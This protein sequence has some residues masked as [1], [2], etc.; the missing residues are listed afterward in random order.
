MTE[1]SPEEFE[2][3][4]ARVAVLERMYADLKREHEKVAIFSKNIAITGPGPL[5]PGIGERFSGGGLK[6]GFNETD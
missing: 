2:A 4:K 6:L 1:V 5:G 3:L